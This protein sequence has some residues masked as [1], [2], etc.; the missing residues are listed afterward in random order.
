MS[1]WKNRK[2]ES[3]LSYIW[4]CENRVRI[5]RFIEA[6]L[7]EAEERG[8]QKALYECAGISNRHRCNYEGCP[9]RFVITKRMREL[10]EEKKKEPDPIPM[11]PLDEIDRGM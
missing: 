6:V 9:C 3:I 1:K 4:G 8:R 11:P 2:A 10:A 7:Q 5:I